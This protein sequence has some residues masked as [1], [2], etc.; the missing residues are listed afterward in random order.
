MFFFKY[1][2][3]PVVSSAPGTFLSA[4]RNEFFRE[5]YVERCL[6]VT[7]GEF[8]KPAGQADNWRVKCEEVMVNY[9][10]NIGFFTIF[11]KGT[12]LLVVR[13]FKLMEINNN[14]D[15]SR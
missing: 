12:G 3:L 14:L 15:F 2:K 11:L 10:E 4:P 13:G 5:T 7:F 1:K 9:L 8:P 6:G